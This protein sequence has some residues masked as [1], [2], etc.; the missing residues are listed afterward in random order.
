MKGMSA[1]WEVKKKQDERNSPL[2]RVVRRR[3]IERKF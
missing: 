1:V 3:W 2:V